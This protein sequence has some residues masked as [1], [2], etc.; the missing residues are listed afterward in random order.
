[1]SLLL[2]SNEMIQGVCSFWKYRK[3]PGI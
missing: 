2:P 3:S 1:M